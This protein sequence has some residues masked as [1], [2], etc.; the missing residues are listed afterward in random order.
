M[1]KFLSSISLAG[2]M[3]GAVLFTDGTAYAATRSSA[4]VSS[5]P[6]IQKFVKSSAPSRRASVSSKAASKSTAKKPAEACTVLGNIGDKKE[7]I[8]HVPGCPN[9]TQTKIQ[10]SKGERIFCSE[11]E[12]I[13]AGWRK[14]KNCPR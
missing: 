1:K 9:Y 8:F 6:S 7:K 12:A 3:L 14:A 10:P 11:E 13:A 5:K 4:S 2:I